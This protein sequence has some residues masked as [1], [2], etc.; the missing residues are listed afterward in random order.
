MG[1]FYKATKTNFLDYLDDYS[2]YSPDSAKIDSGLGALEV[3]PK[4]RPR[5]SEIVTSYEDEMNTLAKTLQQ[6]PNNLS[7]LQPQ[8]DAL[9]NRIKQ[10]YF[11]GELAAARDRLKNYQNYEKKIQ[12]TLKDYPTLQSLAVEKLRESVPDLSFDPKTGSYGQVSI[13]TNIVKP[14]TPDDIREWQSSQ[15]ASLRERILKSGV[16]KVAGNKYES[17]LRVGE[18]VGIT[19]QDALEMLRGAVPRQALEAS[20]MRADLMGL[21]TDEMNIFNEDG[22]PNLNTEWGRIVDATMKQIAGEKFQG[23]TT[24]LEDYGAKKSLEE[25]YRG[26]DAK[27]S[28]DELFNKF[29]AVWEGKEGAFDKKEGFMKFDNFL[30]GAK[31]GGKKVIGIQKIT[32]QSPSAIVETGKT[33]KQYIDPEDRSTYES[34]G[35]KVKKDNDGLFVELPETAEVPMDFDMMESILPDKIYKEFMKRARKEGI[36]DPNTRAVKVDPKT[37]EQQ[38]KTTIKSAIQDSLDKII[39]KK[40]E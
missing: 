3:L 13:P 35:I 2:T 30:E 10:D 24:K 26:K 14:M 40:N 6:S 37:D 8:I 5:V 11:Y 29:K 39:K 25:Y 12:D 15:K 16:E 9:R 34:G 33:R 19:P 32:G 22:S 28:A 23:T 38:V 18:M 21:G 17:I 4:D 31:I 20:Q 36:V 27:E 7:K 1:R